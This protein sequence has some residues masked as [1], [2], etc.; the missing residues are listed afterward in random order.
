MN[1][2]KYSID[3]ESNIKSIKKTLSR[4]IVEKREFINRIFS[5]LKDAK[6]IIRRSNS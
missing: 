1:F 2:I 3:L 5:K 6:I 4:Y